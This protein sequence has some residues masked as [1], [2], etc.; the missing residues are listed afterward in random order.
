MFRGFVELTGHR[1]QLGQGNLHLHTCNWVHSLISHPDNM[2]WGMRTVH[3][4]WERQSSDPKLIYVYIRLYMFPFPLLVNILNTV[5]DPAAYWYL[6]IFPCV[7]MRKYLALFVP[8]ASVKLN[9][10]PIPS[11]PWWSSIPSPGFFLQ[12]NITLFCLMLHVGEGHWRTTGRI[13]ECVFNTDFTFW[14]SNIV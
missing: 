8:A 12:Y 5:C 9:S 10:T 4:S 13:Q 3:P 6:C 14:S 7:F 2:E 11:P 1:S